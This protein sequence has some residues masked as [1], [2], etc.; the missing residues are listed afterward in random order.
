MTV[1][2]LLGEK[3]IPVT[4]S[5]SGAHG[6]APTIRDV[7]REAGVSK[8]LVSMV[9]N[10]DPRVSEAKRKLVH[11]AAAGLGYTPNFAARSLSGGGNFIAVL[12]ADL[13]NPL[14]GEILAEVRA[15]LLVNGHRILITNANY[16][17]EHGVE[18]VDVDGLSM[19]RGL[20]PTGVI[21]VGTISDGDLSAHLPR[22]V[23]AVIING[24][25][26]DRPNTRAVRTHDEKGIRLL[27]EHLA[28]RG[29]D[30]VAFVGGEGGEVARQRRDAFVRLAPGAGI[31]HASVISADL[32]EESGEHAAELL[33]SEG[34]PDAVVAVNDLAAIGVMTGLERNGVRVPDG[35]A[36]AGYDNT[37]LSGIDR[38]SLTSVDHGNV[39]LGAVA[40]A[41][42]LSA[43]EGDE[44]TGEVLV[45]PTLVVRG[46]TGA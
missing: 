44:L 21:V 25:G 35:C 34:V 32:T 26:V 9:F 10:D 27:L 23:P 15:K 41:A 7:A 22:G 16:L 12:V 4:V 3:G 39:R 24:E 29:A 46:S 33:L 31:A 5:E 20:R 11:E 18:R 37:F 8:S 1:G 14:F 38:I 2:G 30:R 36:V 6:R 42:M 17:D 13:H 45:E 19:I 43:L 28:S 40:V